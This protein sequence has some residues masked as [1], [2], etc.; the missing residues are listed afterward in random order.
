MLL[1]DEVVRPCR[2]TQIRTPASHHGRLWVRP[3]RV[4]Y[5]TAGASLSKMQPEIHLLAGLNGAGKTTLARQ[6]EA[7]LPAVRFSLDEWMLLLYDLSFDDELYPSRADTCRA[8]IWDLAAQV[9]RTGSSVVLDWNMWSRSRRAEAVDRAAGLGVTC[10]LHHVV[11]SEETAIERVTQ[12][13]DSR[14]HQLD[15]DA[16]RHLARLFETPEEGEGFVLHSVTG[17]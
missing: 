1:R 12:R 14:A 9:V 3:A 10:H 17:R 5:W 7:T 8:V 6:L 15:A 4:D 16:V 11:V 2:V 13:R